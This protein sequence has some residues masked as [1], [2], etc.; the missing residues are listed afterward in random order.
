MIMAA[1]T[2]YGSLLNFNIRNTVTNGGN[3]P[4][5]MKKFQ[6][7]PYSV[8]CSFDQ[9]QNSEAVYLVLNLLCQN[10]PNNP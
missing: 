4:K 10:H 1:N 6:Y 2:E 3:S 5:V 7:K 8:T 9:L